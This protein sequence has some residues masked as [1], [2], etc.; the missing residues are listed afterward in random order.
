MKRCIKIVLSSILTLI[1][2]VI[3]YAILVIKGIF[4][5]PFIDTKDLVCTVKEFS[6]MTDLVM[7]FNSFRDEM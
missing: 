4:P 3:I 7:T 2:L 6:Y 5:N 1:T